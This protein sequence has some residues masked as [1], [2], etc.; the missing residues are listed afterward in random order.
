MKIDIKKL[1]ACSERCG[2][3]YVSRPMERG[4]FFVESV[5]NPKYINGK[6]EKYNKISNFMLRINDYVEK[7]DEALKG[8]EDLDKVIFITKEVEIIFDYPFGQ[9]ASFSLGDKSKKNEFTK[10]KL[11]PFI[12]L[13]YNHLYAQ[14]ENSC[15][16]KEI[17][18]K[19]ECKD[20]S[21]KLIS[22]STKKTECAICLESSNSL[23]KV[24]CSHVFHEE[25]LAKWLEKNYS[26]PTC[27]K[28]I[29]N[30]CGK[31]TLF[32]TKKVKVTTKEDRINMGIDLKREKTDGKN[33]IYDYD[34]EDLYIMSMRFDEKNNRLFLDVNDGRFNINDIMESI[35]Q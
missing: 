4:G 13:I 26:C 28:V 5:P 35:S 15:S 1:H 21:G 27:R 34:L 9:Y 2:Y 7:E 25:C 20:C 3:T 16:G 24:S 33:K 31:E 23:V 32:K 11:L 6:C 30:K 14:E 17:K 18:L 8:I 10:R 22:S 12:C 29:C 19:K